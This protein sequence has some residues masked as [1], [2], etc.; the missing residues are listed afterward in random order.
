MLFFH[1]LNWIEGSFRIGIHFFLCPRA[2][3]V[4]W[5]V[6][7]AT[8]MPTTMLPTPNSFLQFQLYLQ[9]VKLFEPK[10]YSPTWV[11]A[12]NLCSK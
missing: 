9:N 10:L 3:Q 7:K 11:Q 1:L 4:A 12:L 8:V 5:H 2:G 6:V